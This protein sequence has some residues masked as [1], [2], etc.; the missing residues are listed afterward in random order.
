MV[1][2]QRVVHLDVQPGH[3]LLHLGLRGRRAVEP[4]DLLVTHVEV[5]PHHEVAP[6]PVTVDQLRLHVPR[7]DDVALR[8]LGGASAVHAG[9]DLVATLGDL[10]RASQADAERADDARLSGAVGTD[11]AVELR[12]GVDDLGIGVRHEVVQLH[13][14][15]SALG[16][17]ATHPF[18]GLV[19]GVGVAPVLSRTARHVTALLLLCSPAHRPP[20]VACSWVA[21]EFPSGRG[22]KVSE[23]GQ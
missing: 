10:E 18:G 2:L 15:D 5:D 20:C 19:F 8:V 9:A 21:G 23:G 11:D 17:G 22:T 6:G 3:T 13:T 1:E 16:V 12:T 14:V 7:V 4:P